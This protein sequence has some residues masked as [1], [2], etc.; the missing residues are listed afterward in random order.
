VT[1]GGG[2]LVLSASEQ[3][4]WGGTEQTP[5]GGRCG[6]RGA[7][8]SAGPFAA[9]GE[10][11]LRPPS[12]EGPPGLNGDRRR[13]ARTQ[14]LRGRHVALSEDGDQTGAA[15][16][17]RPAWPRDAPCQE[18]PRSASSS[19]TVGR[20]L[21]HR[22]SVGAASC[23]T[24]ASPMLRIEVRITGCGVARPPE[25]GASSVKSRDLSALQ[26][27]RVRAGGRQ[28]EGLEVRRPN[29]WRSPEKTSEPTTS[30]LG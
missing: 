9:C 12:L 10:G 19:V 7:T 18:H 11:G 5:W 28:L 23:E 15:L 24:P 1:T 4:A 3:S 16:V 14:R 25:A 27:R 6:Q 8:R 29:A 17:A 26:L 30:V 22:R 13:R 20:P 2:W 21:R